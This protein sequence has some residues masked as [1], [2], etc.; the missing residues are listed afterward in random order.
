MYTYRYGWTKSHVG[1]TQQERREE[2]WGSTLYS[3]CVA[4]PCV[5]SLPLVAFTTSEQPNLHALCSRLLALA[6]VPLWLHCFVPARVTYDNF[7]KSPLHPHSSLVFSYHHSSITMVSVM[8][9][10]AFQMSSIGHLSLL[11]WTVLQ[12]LWIWC[13]YTILAASALDNLSYHLTTPR[14]EYKNCIKILPNLLMSH[15]VL[16]GAKLIFQT[17]FSH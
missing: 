13:S 12:R 4:R 6:F 7:A 8:S 9:A 10:W 17:L 5:V 15:A 2:T 11:L 16:I 14:G 1:E 3:L